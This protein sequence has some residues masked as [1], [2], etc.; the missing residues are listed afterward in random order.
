MIIEEARDLV[1]LRFNWTSALEVIAFRSYLK[2]LNFKI[3]P[4]F[5]F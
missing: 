5:E 2:Y 3:E 4:Q 1:F